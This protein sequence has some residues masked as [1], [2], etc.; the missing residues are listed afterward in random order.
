MAP[1][2]S[3]WAALLAAGALLVSCVDGP[4][5]VA[6]NEPSLLTTDRLRAIARDCGIGTWPMPMPF[7]RVVGSEFQRWALQ[8]FPGGPLAENFQN[9][10]T[11]GRE[12]LTLA[13]RGG[14]V[15]H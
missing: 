8:A 2:L 6:D 7:N 15:L 14:P 12:Q 5:R 9:L 10:R 1:R 13:R 4:E 3:I 11:P